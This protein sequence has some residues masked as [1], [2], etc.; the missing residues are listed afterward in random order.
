M[1]ALLAAVALTLASPASADGVLGFEY[2]PAYAWLYAPDTTELGDGRVRM[3]FGDGRAAL[4]T[5][6]QFWYYEQIYKEV[7][8]QLSF[9]MPVQQAV[10]RAQHAALT[11]MVRAHP[12]LRVQGADMEPLTVPRLLPRIPGVTVRPGS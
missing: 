12:T 9:R 8:A 10:P 6:N 4:L 11:A 2:D 5:P 7:L 3:V 1:K